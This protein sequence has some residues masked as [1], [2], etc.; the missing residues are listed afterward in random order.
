[1]TGWVLTEQQIRNKVIE[2][3]DMCNKARLDM[4]II[5]GVE[6]GVLDADLI[7]RAMNEELP[8]RSHEVQRFW[9]LANRHGR[10]N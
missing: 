7:R 5:S 1:M 4:W 10:W 3:F 9:L 8:R 2:L 6:T